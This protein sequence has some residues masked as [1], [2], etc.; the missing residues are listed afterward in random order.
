MAAS[1]SSTVTAA[2]RATPRVACRSRPP[3]PADLPRGASLASWRCPGRPSPGPGASVPR[4][5]WRAHSISSLRSEFT[6]RSYLRRPPE[7]E[8]CVHALA[9]HLG[10]TAERPRAAPASCAARGHDARQTVQPPRRRL[11]LRPHHRLVGQ[12]RRHLAVDPGAQPGERGEG[13]VAQRRLDHLRGGGVIQLDDLQPEGLL[14]GEMIAERALRN[15]RRVDDVPDAGRP[16]PMRVHHLKP[17]REE[18]VAIGRPGHGGQGEHIG[19]TDK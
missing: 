18:L 8:G 10:R 14:R 15:A 13:V 5:A 11:R 9:P 6:P 1:V 17:M 16:E 7:G 3:T 4:E 19:Q 12:K 2:R